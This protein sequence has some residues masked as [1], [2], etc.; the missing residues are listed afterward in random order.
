[1]HG[2]GVR[3]AVLL[4]WL[5]KL[6]RRILALEFLESMVTS[7]GAE[8]LSNALRAELLSNAL[9]AE[10]Y[11]DNTLSLKCAF[12]GAF[13]WSARRGTPRDGSALVVS[14]G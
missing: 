14:E 2:V 4:M 13:V 9:R 11:S 7:F 3:C 1:M 8:L 10:L 6:K 5:R 12:L